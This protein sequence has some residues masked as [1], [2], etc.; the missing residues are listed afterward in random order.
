MHK[1]L[2]LAVILYNL[3][4]ITLNNDHKDYCASTGCVTIRPQMPV[5]VYKILLSEHEF[6]CLKEYSGHTAPAVTNTT[7]YHKEYSCVKKKH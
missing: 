3:S 1:Y 2:V 5:M 4:Q 7:L 6:P